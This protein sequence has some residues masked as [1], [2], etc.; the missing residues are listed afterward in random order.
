MFQLS[1]AADGVGVAMVFSFKNLYLFPE[2]SFLQFKFLLITYKN[3]LLRLRRK[4]LGYENLRWET[5]GTNVFLDIESV[6]KDAVF[7]EWLFIRSNSSGF[8]HTFI[9]LCGVILPTLGDILL[10]QS[11]KGLL[12]WGCAEPGELDVCF[13]MFSAALAGVLFLRGRLGATLCF[14]SILRFS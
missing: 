11:W 12:G 2:N 1:K 7:M 8:W 13:C 14:Q 3:I 9:G 5:Y 10:L 6:F 4:A